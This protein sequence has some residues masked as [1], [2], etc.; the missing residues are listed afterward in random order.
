MW[1]F[2]SWNVELELSSFSNGSSTKTRD[3]NVKEANFSSGVLKVF[4]NTL[5][6]KLIYF[7]SQRVYI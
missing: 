7:I 4:I 3:A 1:N 5:N 2:N 6:K